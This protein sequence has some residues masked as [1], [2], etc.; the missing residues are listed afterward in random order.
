MTVVICRPQDQGQLI[1]QTEKQLNLIYGVGQKSTDYDEVPL[2]KVKL[3]F[4]LFLFFELK[5]TCFR[6]AFSFIAYIISP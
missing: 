4:N 5:V 1:L 6:R 2:Y 3:L